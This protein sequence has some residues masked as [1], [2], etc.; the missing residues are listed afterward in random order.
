MPLDKH[1]ETNTMYFDMPFILAGRQKGGVFPQ[2]S[3]EKFADDYRRLL[4]NTGPGPDS[5]RTSLGSAENAT[6]Q[7]MGRS[8]MRRVGSTDSVNSPEI[9]VVPD[10]PQWAMMPSL[11][12]T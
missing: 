3:E 5:D 7:S 6:L 12:R 11:P 10:S 4:H 9:T 8:H 2:T 1:S